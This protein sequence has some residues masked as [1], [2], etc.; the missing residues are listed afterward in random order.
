VT[1]GRRFDRIES[2]FFVERAEDPAED[3][4]VCYVGG[5]LRCCGPTGVF[6]LSDGAGAGL[7]IF[8]RDGGIIYTRD[9]DLVIKGSA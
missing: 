8:K 2:L 7:L 4:E 9:G 1:P 3:G 5:E 6:T